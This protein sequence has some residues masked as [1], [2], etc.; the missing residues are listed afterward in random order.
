MG[1]HVYHSQLSCLTPV[2]GEFK[3]VTDIANMQT[4]RDRSG[5]LYTL[6]MGINKEYINIKKKNPVVRISIKIPILLEIILIYSM[7]M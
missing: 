6:K 1:N 7:I 2:S 4:H 5:G 3:T